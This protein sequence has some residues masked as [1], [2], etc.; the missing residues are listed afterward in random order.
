MSLGERLW[1]LARAEISAAR[2]K[3]ADSARGA[4]TGT[5][6]DS[7][8]SDGRSAD[9]DAWEQPY[10]VPREPEVDPA[11]RRYYANLELPVGASLP[12]VKAAYKRLVRTYHP[13]RHGQDPAAA[14]ITIELRTAYEALE[15][16]LSARS[17][18]TRPR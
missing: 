6:R 9:H 13:D 10:E 11:I 5:A 4:W 15:T 14:R 3:L 8:S 17:H 18:D 12:E 1:N 16:H 7:A 2:R